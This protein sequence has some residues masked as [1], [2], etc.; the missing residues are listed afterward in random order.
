MQ[1]AERVLSP[2]DA[3]RAAVLRRFGRT[4]GWWSRS[5][6]DRVA[7]MFAF[8]VVT[9]LALAVLAPRWALALGPIVLGVPHILADARYLV[10]RPGYHRR[11]ALLLTVLPCLVAGLWTA[12][13]A[14]AAVAADRKSVV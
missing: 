12:D 9:S 6:E 10:V 7:S 11:R 4:A 3:L 8:G 1:V 14:W 13:L 2:I 5:R